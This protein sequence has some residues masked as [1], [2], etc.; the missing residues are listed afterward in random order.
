MNSLRLLAHEICFFREYC[1][2][3]LTFVRLV[4]ILGGR[5][6]TVT[7]KHSAPAQYLGF[8]LQ[9]V[10]LCYHLLTCGHGDQIS[11][12]HLADVAIHR[13][14]GSAVLQ[15]CKSALKQNPIAD[16]TPDLWK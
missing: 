2:Q 4:G 7:T 5:E 13:P 10:R 3:Q 1:P 12:E 14:D 6:T 11:L 9:P 15:Q 16:W 8:G